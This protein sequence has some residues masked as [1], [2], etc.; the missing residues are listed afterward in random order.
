VAQETNRCLGAL[1]IDMVVE[2]ELH[3]LLSVYREVD[4]VGDAYDFDA[5]GGVSRDDDGTDSEQVGTD[6]SYQHRIDAGHNDRAIGGQIICGGTGG[7]RDDDAVGAEGGYGLAVDLYREVAHASDGSFGDD[8]VIERVP[9][10]NELAVTD[11]LRSHH[12]TDL[13]L[14]AVVAPGL[15]G[16]VEL[17]ERD[18]GEEAEGAEVD[19]KD[20]GGG[21]GEGAGCSEEGAVATE[22]DDQVGLVPGEV[23]SS[24]GVDARDIG[25]AVWVEKVVIVASFEPRDEV[26]EDAGKFRLLGLGDNGSLEH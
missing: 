16:G 7:R 11:D 2:T 22:N 15:E 25:R 18:L 6:G 1:A 26:A 14:G 19:A 23:Y 17:G 13:D 8:D 24:D 20:G 9:C 5:Y 4:L 21:A 12:A 10:L 3:R